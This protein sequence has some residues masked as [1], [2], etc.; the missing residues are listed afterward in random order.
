M[1]NE[2]EFI[3]HNEMAEIEE[4]L[5]K[6]DE[7]R[8]SDPAEKLMQKDHEK[9]IEGTIDVINDTDD[10]KLAGDEIICGIDLGTSNSCITIWRNNKPEVIPNYRRSVNE[11]SVKSHGNLTIPSFVAFGNHT[12]YIGVE[13]KNQSELN[14]E[15][16]YYEVKR[17]IGRTFN[18]RNVQ[19]DKNF[20]TYQFECGDNDEIKLLSTKGRKNKYS[21]EEIIAMIL[22]ELK[23][24]AENYL[25]QTVNKVVISVPAYF[26]DNQRLAIKNACIIAGL[27][28]VRIINEP[29]AAALAYG[30]VKNDKP[31]STILV[32]DLG[33]GTLDVCVMKL[34]TKNWTFRVLASS[35]NTHLGGSDFDHYLMEYCKDFFLKKN[36]ITNVGPINSSSL[37]LLKKRC[38]HAKHTLSEKK[39]ATV[40]IKNFYVHEDSDGL[41]KH[42]DLCVTLTREKFEKICQAMFNVCL[43]PV[44]DVLKNCNLEPS[45]IDDVILVGGSTKIPKIKENLKCFF[46]KEPNSGVNPDTIVS[47]GCAIQ[48]YI[49]NH[50]DDPYSTKVTLL[51]VIPLSLG[52]ETMREI[53]T[54]IIPRNSIIPIRKTK[55]FYADEDNQTSLNIKI[56]EGERKLTKDNYLIGSF[57]LT[58]LV[59]GPKEL[60]EIY[61]TLDVGIDGIIDVTA[62]DRRDENNVKTVKITSKKSTLSNEEIKEM[63]KESTEWSLYD[64][65]ANETKRIQYEISDLCKTIMKNVDD[66]DFQLHE[67]DRK[68][69]KDDI[70]RVVAWL[71][72]LANDTNNVKIDSLKDVLNKIKKNY[73]TLMLRKNKSNDNVKSNNNE[74]NIGVSVF[75]TEDDTINMIEYQKIELNDMFDDTTSEDEKK[76]ILEIREQ[77]TCMCYEIYELVNKNNVMS[78][79]DKTELINIIDDNLIWIHVTEKA[80][81][82]EYLSQMDDLN[83][84][85]NTILDNYKNVDIL[86]EQASEI[87]LNSPK[88]M[89]EQTCY[90]LM[91]L[92]KNNV[93]P[94]DDIDRQV[95]FDA[96]TDIMAWLEETND[97]PDEQYKQKKEA[98][99]E[100]SKTIFD[101]MKNMHINTE[102]VINAIELN[103]NEILRL[104]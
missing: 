15:N 72:D 73:G 95:L 54:T 103:N 58:G 88:I 78:D 92:I 67:T 64:K 38:E 43:K 89:L 5:N 9:Y 14:P 93:L 19:L 25:K 10:I 60:Q 66:P 59:P 28:C 13:A 12:R 55:K 52:I 8:D 45:D 23:T 94:F 31:E 51:D 41:K 70:T 82:N 26:H 104:E 98:I 97:L 27:D 100:L 69:V 36:N 22:S 49:I 74:N 6:I 3:L 21:P 96:V 84:S 35:G 39:I 87:N 61:V 83:I 75:N 32:Y 44:D 24:N 76:Q 2:H 68:N 102:G 91:S 77:F 16:T 37:Q 81:M 71:T 20:L 90:A 79:N 86:N 62:I 4:L 47:I 30:Y 53:M 85:V 11:N 34:N 101:N 80:K 40:A 57:E 56:Y 46:G 1:D 33:G 63:I 99:D 48:G 50:K 18:D 17:L 65:I 42:L 7:E 29:T